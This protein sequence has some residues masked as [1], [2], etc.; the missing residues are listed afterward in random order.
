MGNAV[1][2]ATVGARGG[3]RPGWLCVQWT[4]RAAGAG[5]TRSAIAVMAAG[6]SYIQTDRWI[7]ELLAWAATDMA[8][9]P[10][11][12][13]VLNR[14]RPP[15]WVVALDA[16]ASANHDRESARLSLPVSGARSR[17]TFRERPGALQDLRY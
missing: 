11:A 13:P 8:Q 6:R 9:A 17:P 5:A 12:G 15:Y 1:V 10:E 7:W 2:V 16:G 14:V 4:Q 3:R